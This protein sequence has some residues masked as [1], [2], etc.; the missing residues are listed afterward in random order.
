[1][2]GGC[3]TYPHSQA[4]IIPMIIWADSEESWINGCTHVHVSTVGP[5]FPHALMMMS[6]SSAKCTEDCSAPSKVIDVSI[7]KW[8]PSFSCLNIFLFS[9]STPPLSLY[10]LLIHQDTNE[11]GH[12]Q[13]SMTPRPNQPW[14][15]GCQE[16]PPPTSTALHLF[17]LSLHSTPLT[18]PPTVTPHYLH[19]LLYLMLLSSACLPVTST[20]PPSII[21]FYLECNLLLAFLY[22]EHFLMLV[23]WLRGISVSSLQADQQVLRVR[24][25]VKVIKPISLL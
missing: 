13:A 6:E 3:E 12:C 20:I 5:G 4:F 24:I 9:F 14:S 22:L 15:H 17:L 23:R 25:Q 21:S 16:P 1:M 2:E 8:P 11:V 7:W 10:S 19:L 18:V